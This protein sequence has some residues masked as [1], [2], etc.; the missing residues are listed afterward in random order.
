M[1][2]LFIIGHSNRSLADYLVLLAEN[3]IEALAETPR[4]S[5]MCAEALPWRCHRRLVADQFV[6]LGWHVYDIVGQHNTR[7]HELPPFAVVTGNQ[8]TYP[9]S[10]MRPNKPVKPSPKP[11]P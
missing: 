2:S 8:V 6:A 11:L 7:P 10:R 1:P 3:E 9:G 5:I 4:T